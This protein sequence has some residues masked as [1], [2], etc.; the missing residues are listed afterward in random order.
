[1]TVDLARRL[2][3]TEAV[4][5]R[6]I[7]VALLEHT[8]AA[9]H[10]LVALSDRVAH[11]EDLIE[12][13]CARSP[14]PFVKSV[15]PVDQLVQRL[16][17]GM[18]RR[19]LGV[20]VR[21]DVRT[22]T[23]DVAVADPFDRH[24]AREFERALDSP[25]R[26]V[27]GSLAEVAGA[28]SDADDRRRRTSGTPAFGTEVRRPSVVPLTNIADAA[29]GGPDTEPPQ[30]QDYGARGSVVP[31]I[32]APRIPYISG[33]DSEPVIELTRNKAAPSIQAPG[34]EAELLALESAE[35]ATDVAVG[36][37]KVM[38]S[39]ASRCLV[40]TVHQA[41]YRAR[42]S[43]PPVEPRVLGGLVVSSSEPNVLNTALQTGYYLGPLPR[44]V[45][46]HGLRQFA[47]FDDGEVAVG[48]VYVS[49]RPTLT[50]LAGGFD[51][52]FNATRRADTIATVAGRSL[53]RILRNK[54]QG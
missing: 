21:E 25:V 48:V 13:E 8:L 34:V 50:F 31:P 47:E 12:S 51:N 15:Q 11:L 35:A 3:N 26:L 4:A 5:A 37:A 29:A 14:I 18:C 23:I 24:A 20:P 38:L 39:V 41:D 42:A 30:T 36:V 22:G 28:A 16:P 2:L 27:R 52:A 53:E 33:P 10:F 54:K 43:A 49:G 1:M 7:E 44:T 9:R 40:F 17:T 32:A 45:P 46:H 6:D 19:L